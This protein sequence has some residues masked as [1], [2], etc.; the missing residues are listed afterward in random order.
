[1]AGAKRPSGPDARSRR[2]V[3][4]VL[5]AGAAVMGGLAALL[6]SGVLPAGEGVRQIVPP[7]LVAV[8]VIDV[9]VGAWFLFGSRA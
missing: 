5:L 2:V 6:A 1:M 8:A 9:I 4:A 3:G 7:V